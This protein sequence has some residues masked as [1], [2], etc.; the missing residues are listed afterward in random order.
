MANLLSQVDE[1]WSLY[2]F[3][4]LGLMVSLMKAAPLILASPFLQVNAFCPAKFEHGERWRSSQHVLET[5]KRRNERIPL[6]LSPVE[7]VS[8]WDELRL[9]QASSLVEKLNVESAGLLVA[10]TV[11][12]IVAP[13]LS[14]SPPAKIVSSETVDSILRGTFLQRAQ[15]LRCV[16]KSS[17]DG[18][19]ALDFHKRVDEMGS[20]VV[21]AISSS[22]KIFGGY[23]PTGWRSSDDYYTSTAAFLWCLREK[24][25]VKLPILAGG[26]AAVF[27][28]ATGGP[29]FSSDLQIGAPQAA[30][31]GGFAGPDMEDLS[32]N[33]GNLRL[34]K[35]SVG[36][37]YDWDDAW[38]A[39]GAF[40]LLDVEVYCNVQ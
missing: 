36:I 24:E 10:A 17:R 5:W 16:Y 21:V 34:G 22:R 28:Y 11:A 20:G 9:D 3:V 1:S 8:V 23:N 19:S 6:N 32:I 39:R 18:W 29:C 25:V 40:R 7:A 4:G 35:S 27:D 26:N 13:F 2:S 37:T 12:L 15:N 38:P 14:G 31:L 30:V 33:A